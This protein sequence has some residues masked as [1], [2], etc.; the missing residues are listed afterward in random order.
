MIEAFILFAKEQYATLSAVLHVLSSTTTTI[1]TNTFPTINSTIW[2][3]LTLAWSTT[4]KNQ[5]RSVRSAFIQFVAFYC[6]FGSLIFAGIMYS[7]ENQAG[8]P[9]TFVDCRIKCKPSFD[10]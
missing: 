8:T 9:R 6:L 10:G 2:R 1:N 3:K 5:Q 4:I 7:I